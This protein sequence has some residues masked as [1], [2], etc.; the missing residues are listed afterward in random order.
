[1]D[2][3]DDKGIPNLDDCTER[4]RKEYEEAFRTLA[5]YC[6]QKSLACRYRRDGTIQLA[7]TLETRC[8][9]LYQELPAW[10]KW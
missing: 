10:A 1:M 7:A 8:E 3:D 5:I 4:E 6:G 2:N 9:V